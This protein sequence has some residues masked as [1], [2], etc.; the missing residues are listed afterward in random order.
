MATLAVSLIAAL[1]IPFTAAPA[2]AAPVTDPNIAAGKAGTLFTLT[3][4]SMEGLLL[5]TSNFGPAGTE[6]V[7]GEATEVTGECEKGAIGSNGM[8]GA[9]CVDDAVG[10]AEVETR[11]VPSFGTSSR[12][13]TNSASICSTYLAAG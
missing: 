9:G 5:D 6:M 13:F 7:M 8:L 11:M 12:S 2:G 4:S 10:S 1:L 3:F